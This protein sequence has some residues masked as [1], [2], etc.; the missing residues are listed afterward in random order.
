MVSPPSPL[1]SFLCSL[2]CSSDETL[3]PCVGS[4]STLF[5]FFDGEGESDDGEE[6]EFFGGV[7]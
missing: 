5:D 1:S 6:G 7:L 2:M 4:A 3:L